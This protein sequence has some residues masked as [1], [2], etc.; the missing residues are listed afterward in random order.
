MDGYHVHRPGIGQYYYVCSMQV[1][2]YG[3]RPGHGGE[4]QK[5]PALSPHSAAY[6]KRR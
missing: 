6:S 4:A 3:G 2:P 1:F 5:G